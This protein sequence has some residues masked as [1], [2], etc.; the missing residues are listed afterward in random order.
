MYISV[1]NKHIFSNRS[2]KLMLVPEQRYVVQ[3]D[4]DMNDCNGKKIYEG[5]ICKINERNIVGVI[6]YV[7]QHASYYLLDEK[8]FKYYPLNKGLVEK[9]MEIIGNVL[10]NNNLLLYN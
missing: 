2:H 3:Y 6:V 10:E 8:N 5:D 7:S 9:R 1:S 4:I